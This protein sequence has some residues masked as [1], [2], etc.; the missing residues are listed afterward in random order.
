[1]YVWV[2]RASQNERQLLAFVRV[3]VAPVRQELLH[4]G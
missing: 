3:T 4:I 2:T 1:M